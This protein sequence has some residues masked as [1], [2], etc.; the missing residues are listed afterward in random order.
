MAG[1][2]LEKI[3]M[4][5]SLVTQKCLNPLPKTTGEVILKTTAGGWQVSVDE[6]L[7]VWG[8]DSLQ[9][10]LDTSPLQHSSQVVKRSVFCDSTTKRIWVYG[11][12]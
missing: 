6:M 10:V 1:G 2:T 4:R 11:H 8:G 7:E 5:A 12:M 9:E 3:G